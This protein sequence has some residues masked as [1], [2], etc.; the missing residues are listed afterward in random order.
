MLP[1]EDKNH[2]CADGLIALMQYPWWIRMVAV[3]LTTI[4]ITLS[5]LFWVRRRSK[6]NEEAIVMASRLRKAIKIIS[7]VPVYIY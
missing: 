6:S 7:K 2:V 5:W 4:L 3:P 1:S